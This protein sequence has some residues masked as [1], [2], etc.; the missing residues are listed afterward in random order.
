MALSLAVIP[1]Q[2]ALRVNANGWN[3]GGTAQAIRSART[4]H[5]KMWYPRPFPQEDTH[6]MSMGVWYEAEQDRSRPFTKKD[7]PTLEEHLEE[8]KS[9]SRQW[10]RYEA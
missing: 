10:R 4:L 5:R 1:V 7:Y 3:A 9:E 6:N 8:L 2:L